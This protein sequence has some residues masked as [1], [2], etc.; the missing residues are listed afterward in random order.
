MAP[1]HLRTAEQHDAHVR[2]STPHQSA[3]LSAI[4]L[5]EQGGAQSALL[6]KAHPPRHFLAAGAS[7]D[8]WYSMLSWSM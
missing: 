7:T 1:L 6:G 8:W 2:R 4:P 3:R 5:H